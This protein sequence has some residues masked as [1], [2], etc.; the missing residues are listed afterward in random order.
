VLAALA[1]HFIPENEPIDLLNVAFENPRVLKHQKNK[2]D[3]YSVP[4]RIT[5]VLGASE[6]SALF[7]SRKWNLVKINV[8]F[9][10][11]QEYKPL[12][13]SLIKPLDTIMDQSI[14]M[15]FWFASRGKGE[16]DG[17]EYIS[18]AKVL[19]SGL[20]A[21]EQLGGYGRHQVAFQKGGWECLRSELQLDVD[22]IPL[23]NLG[24]DDRI[25]SD[26]GKEVRFPY[27]DEQVVNL[28]CSTP[29]N[30]KTTPSLPKGQGDKMLLRRLALAMGLER[31]SKE[32][33]R[34]VQFGARTAKME[35]SSEKGQDLM[36]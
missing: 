22:R 11:Y 29:V 25:I 6:L 35:D 2:H 34:A 30:L 23:R 1:H 5:G 12:V 7:P 17:V 27:L 14:A 36:I 19:L 18:T 26:H 32:P 3:I 33:K 13:A 9:S 10:I 16:S 20:G 8:P 31:A 28:L 24:R 15:A 21:D 4:D